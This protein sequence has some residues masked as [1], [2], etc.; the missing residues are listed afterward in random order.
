[1]TARMMN[2]VQATL[3]ALDEA[4]AA[5]PSVIVFGEDVADRA[6]GGVMGASAGLSTT[7]GARRVRSTPIAEQAIFGAAVGAA[8]AGMSLVAEIMMMNFI[9]VSLLH[10]VN[11]ASK[12][13]YITR[14]KL[15]L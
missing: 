5:D 2:G 12:I 7:Y 9:P 8:I 6:G 11:H 13:R 1:M 4:M 14:G 15:G 3:M 10:I